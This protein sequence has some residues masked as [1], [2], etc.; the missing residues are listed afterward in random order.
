MKHVLI[1]V[2][3][4]QQPPYDKMVD[5]SE[6]TWASVPVEGC[7]AFFYFGNPVRQNLG[8]RIYFDVNEGYHTMSLK[9]VEAFK[10]ALETQKFD[11]IARVNSSTY[12][13]KDSLLDYVQKLPNEKVFD[14]LVVDG[15]KLWVWGCFFI[16]SRDV[17]QMVVDNA[18]LI[19]YSVMDDVGMSKLLI[20]NLG[21]HPSRGIGCSIDKNGDK[22]R[23]ICYGTESFEFE[24]F[25]DIVKAK[26]HW[27][28]RV[29]QDLNRDEDEYIM[30][31]LFKH[32]S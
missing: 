16:L 6:S 15:V 14:G 24:N 10:W 9:T 8:D 11:Y 3:S 1:M 20:D 23:A 30:K 19:D 25:S 17:V 21:I 12:V 32:F 18:N 4:S 26:S 31:Q 22:W 5:T 13:K 27:G 2:I 7:D 29:K 28:F